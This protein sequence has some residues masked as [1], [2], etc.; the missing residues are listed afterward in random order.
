MEK[1]RDHYNYLAKDK[2]RWTKKN[3][4]YYEQLLEY[5]SFIIPPGSRI[6]EF[7]CGIGDIISNLKPA[8]GVGVD[9]SKEMIRK[10][11]KKHPKINFVCSDFEN[12]KTNKKFDY[13]I[14]SGVLSITK[15]IQKL[16]KNIKE[17]CF[18]EV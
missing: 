14:I 8:Y 12:F 7:G 9:F 16:L 17:F 10:A 4:F 15:N 13:I 18:R 6:L 2:S 1:I 11:K 5:Y 3:K